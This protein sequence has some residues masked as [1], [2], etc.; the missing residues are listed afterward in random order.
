MAADADPIAQRSQAGWAAF[1][2]FFAA[3]TATVAVILALMAIF[4]L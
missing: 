4:L 3:A 1:V 2:K